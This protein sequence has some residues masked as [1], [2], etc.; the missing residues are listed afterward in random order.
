MKNIQTALIVATFGLV[1]VL[2]Q[3]EASPILRAGFDV[4]AT[5]YNLSGATTGSVTATD[6]DA[7]LSNGSVASITIGS[8][9]SPTYYDGGDSSVIRIDFLNPVSAFGLDWYSNNANP[10]LSVFDSGNTLLESLT[11]N[12]TSFPTID[13]FPTGFIGLDVGSNSIAYATIDTP[14][15]GNELYVDNLIY[16]RTTAVP[17]PATL[18]LA[19]IAA[20]GLIAIRRRK[21]S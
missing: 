19:A 4:G 3:A 5:T 6:G 7:N 15:N 8:M 9:V 21:A 11:L 10:T 1:L 17:E 12:W 16:Q 14:L 2:P 13:G 20:A 18:P